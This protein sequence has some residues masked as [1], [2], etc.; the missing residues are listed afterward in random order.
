[1][2]LVAYIQA[3]LDS[4]EAIDPL[5]P[6]VAWSWLVD[7]LECSRRARHRARRHRHRHHIG[8]LRRHLRPAARPPAGAAG[9]VDGDHPWS[10]HPRRRRSA[11]CSSTPRAATGRGDRP[12]LPFPRLTWSSSTSAATRRPRPPAEEP[13]ATPLLHPAEGVPDPLGRP[14]TEIAAA[15]D[16]AGS[17]ARTVRGRRRAGVGFPLLQPGLPD[18]DPAHRRGHRAHR[19]G[20]PRQQTRSTVLEPVAEVLGR[21][22]VDPARRRSGPAVPGRGRHAAAGAVRH[23]ARRP[24]GRLRPGQPGGHGA[25]AAGARVWPRATARPTGPSARCRR[26]GSTTP[27]W[28]WKCSSNCASRSPGCWPSKTKP[29]G[30]QQEFEYL[31]GFDRQGARRADARDVTAGGAHRVSTGCATGAALAA[32]RELWTAR[33]QIAQRRD[34]APRPHP[35]RLGHRRR[36]AR[37]PQDRRRPHRLA[38]LRRHATSAAAPRCGWP[39]WRP[40]GT[41]PIRRTIAEPQNGPPPAGALDQT[42]AGGRRAAGCGPRCAVRAVGS[43]SRCRP[44]TWSHPTWCDGCAGTGRTPTDVGRRRRRVPARRGQARP[45]QR[46]LVV[47][48][49]AAHCELQSRHDGVSPDAR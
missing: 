45:W 28:T 12:G 29:I 47:P 32:V 15:A 17:R 5:L 13:E 31:R 40:P 41:T 25:A 9:V 34:I 39:R 35:A 49:L 7:A 14:P 27:H 38:D 8:A 23:R 22:R 6:E 37:R 1:M 4:T 18:P 2:R 26:T 11:R 30:P 19:P 36:R 24:A 16:A 42:Q 3:D 46:E 20:Q 48:V 33:D 44:R 21:R 43:G 10:R